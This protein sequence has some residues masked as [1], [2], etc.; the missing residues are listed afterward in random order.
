LGLLVIAGSVVIGIGVSMVSTLVAQDRLEKKQQAHALDY[1]RSL[2][3]DTTYTD[4]CFDRP[5]VHT[6]VLR[7][8]FPSLAEMN[9]GLGIQPLGIGTELGWWVGGEEV[10]DAEFDRED[11][12]LRKLRVHSPRTDH[13]QS[14]QSAWRGVPNANEPCR[15]WVTRPATPW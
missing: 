13:I 2:I 8:P 14:V 3:V 1:A 4:P 12:K 10:V 6:H 9:A 7:E 5:E 15:I 11:G